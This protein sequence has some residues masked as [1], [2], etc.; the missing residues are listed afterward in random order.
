M[1]Y[2]QFRDMARRHLINDKLDQ[3]IKGYEKALQVAGNYSLYERN[4]LL[5]ELETAQHKKYFKSY[6]I[7]MD[8]SLTTKC[9]LNCRMCRNK[10]RSWEINKKTFRD[11][12]K[13]IPY[14]QYVNYMGG[15]VFLSK[16]FKQILKASSRNPHI[17]QT[18]TTNGLLINREWASILLAE[19]VEVVFS[20]D[21]FTKN[22]YESIKIGANFHNFMYN[23]K[24][25]TEMRN[26]IDPEKRADL[27]LNFML[28]KENYQEVK[29]A[30]GFAEKYGFNVINILPN[31]VSGSVWSTFGGDIEM[32]RGY[33]KDL[34]PFLKKEAAKKGIKVFNMIPPV[35]RK[36]AQ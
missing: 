12:I 15:E 7:A 19:Q 16:Y 26:K 33:Y 13:F 17:N 31:N 20:I 9:N 11:I 32:A 18:L 24:I 3:A 35:C 10:D 23:I 30:P 29:L 1:V 6:P 22:T 36:I 8:I 2:K 34:L 25:F 21:G 27:K 14:L 28:L 4:K 5:G